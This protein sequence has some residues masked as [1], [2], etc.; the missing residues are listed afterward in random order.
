M[1]YEAKFFIGK[2]DSC[3]ESSASLLWLELETHSDDEDYEDSG[4]TR[5][6]PSLPSLPA[7]IPLQ[8]L[9]RLEIYGGSFKTLWENH[10]EVF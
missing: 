6:P 8:H 1:G 9:Q 7:W 3:V 10:T 5:R 4:E 2:S